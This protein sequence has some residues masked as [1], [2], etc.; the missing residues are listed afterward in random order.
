M[1]LGQAAQKRLREIGL[2]GGL[3][4][5]TLGFFGEKL[6]A[7]AFEQG[8]SIYR[9]GESGRVL[10]VILEGQVELLRRGKDEHEHVARTLSAGQWF[11]EK[12]ILDVQ[13]RPTSARASMPSLLLPISAQDLDGL[14]RRDLKEYALLVL[15]LAR[16]ISRQLRAC[17]ARVFE[18]S[19]A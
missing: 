15:N 19:Q 7:V 8:Q 1:H 2:F 6:S 4:D 9:E 12:S 3:G 5:E 18:L 11:G 13:P 16:E 14:Y 17:E 10:Y